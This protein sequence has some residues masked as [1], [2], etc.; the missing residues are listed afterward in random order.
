VILAA[1]GG[2]GPSAQEKG[3][4]G[5]PEQT[6]IQSAIRQIDFRNMPYPF[7]EAKPGPNWDAPGPAKTITLKDGDYRFPD[8]GY[9]SLVSVTYGDLNGDGREEAAVDLLHGTGGTQNWHYL[10]L[11][12]ERDGHAELMARLVSGS[13]A[14]GGLTR[15]AINANQLIVDF[16]D[17]ERRQGDCCSLGFVRVAY[18]LEGGSFQEAGPRT[19]GSY[20]I[21]VYPLYLDEPESV[22]PSADGSIVFIDSARK[23]H[24]LTSTRTDAEPSLSA[25]KTSVVFVRNKTELWMI[26]S[27]G[28]NERKL[29]SCP[30]AG[31]SGACHSPQFSPDGRSVYFIRELSEDS[32]GVWKLDLSAGSVAQIIQ[33]SAKFGVIMAGPTIGSIVADQ[34]TISSDSSGQQY[35]SYPFFLFSPAGEKIRQVGDD[36]EYLADLIKTLSQ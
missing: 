22:Q 9:L 36:S 7:T 26:G 8:G 23:Q 34:K 20:R 27:D 2:K 31:N 1:C 28:S 10:Y 35:P 18:R 21:N 19:R 32:G 14:Y 24:P 3:S 29:F 6:V 13:R 17:E 4:Q 25:D 11:F 15:V 12:N 33:D 5:V 30:A 16:Q